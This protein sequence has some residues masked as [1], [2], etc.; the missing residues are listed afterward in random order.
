MKKHVNLDYCKIFNFFEKEVNNP[1]R[2]DERQL[3]IKRPNMFSS[4]ISHFFVAKEP[5]KKDDLK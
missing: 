1:L 2:E 3:S 4:S 5:F